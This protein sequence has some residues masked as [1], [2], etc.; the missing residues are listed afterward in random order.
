MSVVEV[1]GVSLALDGV[2]I[3]SDVSL[4][5]RAGEVTVLVGPNGSGKSTL[6]SL[7][8]GERA[9]DT[10]RVTLD[11]DDIAALAP[12]AAAQRRAMLPQHASFAFD[13]SAHQIVALGR[14]PWRRTESRSDAERVVRAALADTESLD[15][16]ERSVRSLSGG[17]LAR[18]ELAR[19]LAQDTACVLLDEPTAA[20]DL[21][22]QDRALALARDI[23]RAGGTVVVVLHDL[24]AAVAVA[25]RVL[26]MDRGTIA[27]DVA[28]DEITAA[29]LERVYQHPV[30]IVRHPVSG[31][32]LI[33]PRRS[34]VERTLQGPPRRH[35]GVS[36]RVR[37]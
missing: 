32:L 2:T 22:H 10:G 9:P 15:N 16:M 24:D 8:A 34:W 31:R 26:V 7:I 23:A 29:L 25:D 12:A 37:A 30:D 3:L 27:A 33:L 28:P 6:L 5:A 4:R 20:L 35:L 13:Y 18:V 17:E 14:R 36:A 11:G 21:R 19:V 1:T